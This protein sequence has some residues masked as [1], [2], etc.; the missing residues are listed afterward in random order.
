[1]S[2]VTDTVDRSETA[3]ESTR[4]FRLLALT[5]AFVLAVSHV[6]VLYYVSTI[7]GVGQNQLLLTVGVTLVAATV[8]SRYVRE[9]VAVWIAAVL[10]AVGAVFY[11]SSIPGGLSLLV[12]ATDKLVADSLALLTGFPIIRIQNVDIWIT[13]YT[14]APLFL[15]WYLALRRRYVPSV[16]VG[17]IALAVFVLTGDAAL[18]TTLVGSLG[19]LAAVGFGE[20]ERRSGAIDQ[21]DALLV[22]IAVVIVVTSTVPVVPGGGSNPM[23]LSPGGGGGGGGS[24]PTLEASLTSAPSETTIQG[25]IQL[26]PEVRFTVF[27][28]ESAYWRVGVY[29]RFT[30]KSWIRTGDS[31]PYSGRL[32]LPPGKANLISQRFT[33][34]DRMSVMP[35]AATPVE[36]GGS[37]SDAA[38]V[39]D[40]QVLRPNRPLEEGTSYSVK[41]AVYDGTLSD[42]ADAGDDDP[43]SVRQTYTQVPSG[44]S[45]AF[46]DR[47]ER[48]VANADNRVEAAVAIQ[49]FL[50]N[51][52]GYSLNVTRPSGNVANAFLLRM[53]EGYC[54]YFATTMTMMLRTQ[55]IPA[56]YVVGYT[57]GQQVGDNQWVVRGLNSHAWVEVYFPDVG[58]VKFD[59]TPGGP[60]QSAEYE[61][62]QSARESGAGNVD[63][64]ESAAVPLTPTPTA[65]PETPVNDSSPFSGGEVPGVDPFGR[66]GA[67]GTVNGTFTQAAGGETGGGGGG[68]PR[69]PSPQDTVFG[70]AILAGV[71]AAAHRYGITDR[72][73]EG[74]RLHWQPRRD[75]EV[76]VE[77][78]FARLELLLGRSVRNR[79]NGETPR[80]YLETMQ[81]LAN[82]GERGERVARLYERAHYGD[83]VSPDEADEAVR[84]VDEIVGE[85]TGWLGSLLTR[86]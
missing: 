86:A 12:G 42:L 23:F 76:D 39:D 20:L 29:D 72:A 15:A 2:T 10:G 81:L 67:N 58:W 78:A 47:T 5:G 69:A 59:P 54:V 45:D 22:T 52:K 13:G 7:I 36:V 80:T 68:L 50:K 75:P 43:P 55:G 24:A 26:S 82:V 46:R 8:L 3:T 79:R 51:R 65:T 16:A 49:R 77:R 37:A 41:S 9:R 1:M 17:G 61:R 56:R 62:I 66:V 64:D 38:L 84:L 14:P 63:T 32:R 25:P 85:R 74:V 6:Q 48:I 21:A 34:E 60:R 70:T 18:K 4:L 31:T 73:V 71:A 28:G 57:P 40:H 19:G 27:A 53:N 83:G 35:A 33:M 30:G 44:I 11:L